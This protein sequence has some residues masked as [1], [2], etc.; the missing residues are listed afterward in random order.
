[1]VNLYTILW[2]WYHKENKSLALQLDHLASEYL[3]GEMDSSRKR[4]AQIW[5]LLSDDQR[6]IYID[7]TVFESWAN[8]LAEKFNLKKP[9]ELPDPN[10]YGLGR[11]KRI[12]P[13]PIRNKETEELIDQFV[14]LLYTK[15][16]DND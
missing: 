1:M 9:F 8:Y 16:Q 12:R 10:Y 3:E 5:R 4:F 14:D 11:W 2:S 7:S 13:N 15:I 6:Q